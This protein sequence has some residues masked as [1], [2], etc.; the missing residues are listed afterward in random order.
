MI[1]VGA[2]Q[3]AEALVEACD[4]FL[5]LEVLEK[6]AAR[7]SAPASEPLVDDAKPPQPASIQ[8][9]LTKALNNVATDDD[10]WAS[11][12]SVGDRLYR[13][14]PS[15]ESRDYGFGKLSDLVKAQPF[16]E[17]KTVTGSG[18]RGQLWCG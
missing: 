2:A 6:S 8:S 5:Y 15:F 7:D 1:G 3:D 14:N 10:D 4:R 13:T 18:G 9:V 16:V 17:T 11:L 12:G